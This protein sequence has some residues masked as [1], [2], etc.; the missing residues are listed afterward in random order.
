[1]TGILKVFGLAERHLLLPRLDSHFFYDRIGK[2]FPAVG[3]RRA[4]VA[5]F[6]G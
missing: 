4:R 2:T 1:M 5:F 6:A 3:E